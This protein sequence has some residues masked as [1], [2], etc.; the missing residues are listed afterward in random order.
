MAAVGG[1]SESDRI[2]VSAPAFRVFD[3]KWL[4]LGAAAA[5]VIW[6]CLV[7]VAFL[8]WRSFTTAAAPGAPAVT[9]L[10]NY[11]TVYSSAET[12]R[13]FRSSL[14]FAS[15]TATFALAI[16]ATF[17][18][19]NERTNTPLK[20]LFFALAIVPL[21]IPGVLF[22]VAW[23]MLASP[24][25][26][27]LNLWIERAFDIKWAPFDV[28]S[29]KGMAWVEGLHSAP[30]AFLLM[31]AAFRSMDPSLEESALMGGASLFSVMRRVTLP[32]VWP[33]LAASFL[34]LF[35][36]A[37]ESFESPTLLGLPAGIQ[38]F[39]SAIYEAL[40]VYPSQVGLASAY[41]ATLLVITS[42]G[43]W[44]QS[45][46]AKGGRRYATITGKGTRP[47]VMDLGR[48]RWLTAGLFVIYTMLVIGLPFLILLWSSL[49]RFYSVPSWAALH[50]VSLYSY[51][52]VLAYPGIG[53][54]IWNSAILA[55]SAATAATFLSALMSWMVLRTRLPG[56]WLI[57]NIASLP[58]VVPGLVLGLSIM[59]CYLTVG[60]GVYGTLWILLIAYVTRFMPYGMRFNSS[61]LLQIHSE[62]EEAAQISGASWTTVFRRIV[63]PLLAPGL[64]AGWI[65]IVI[66]SVRELSSSILLY[67]PGR[68][69]VAVVIWELWQDGQY[70][71]LS[72]LG[73]MLIAALFAFVLAAQLFSRRFALNQA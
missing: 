66:V 9:T 8:I 55:V 23:I 61:S 29:L 72:A 50:R 33:A 13:L 62:L 28:Y 48:W 56:R 53:G 68:E 31:T 15:A 4:V 17:A 65:Y 12:L 34:I 42:G 71:E 36:R 64:A 70:V 35:I 24:K 40:H 69:V 46:I 1:V 10:M 32:L 37:L 3:P 14:S 16:G 45:K 20:P 58:L 63:L 19:M 44:W 47:R 11:R 27:I 73:V 22:V 43:I 21:V 52:S 51:K 67:S 59:I 2:R 26:G 57:D 6:L 5:I 39:T 60:G 25:I 41:A 7:P 30:I 49:Q 18:W 38:V 54:A